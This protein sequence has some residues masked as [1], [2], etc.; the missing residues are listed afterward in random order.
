[1]TAKAP[2]RKR[3]FWL[4]GN[5]YENAIGPSKQEVYASLMPGEQLSLTREPEN[6]YDANAVLVKSGENI[7]GY[8]PAKYSA[9]IAG[10]LD[11]GGRAI[12]NVHRIKGGTAEYPRR[13]I[14]IFVEWQAGK[15]LSHQKLSAEQKAFLGKFESTNGVVKD[16][17]GRPAGC[18]GAVAI[19]LFS[20]I[21][22]MVT[23]KVLFA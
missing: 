2:I 21:A 7:L 4:A 18:F 10:Y 11:S 3:V 23:A 14:E 13:E 17:G 8:L 6:Q 12:A 19:C 16:L 15:R 1:M 5:N 22:L 20:S 9:D